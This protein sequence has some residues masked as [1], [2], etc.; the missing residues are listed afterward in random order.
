MFTKVKKIALF[1]LPLVA[2]VSVLSAG[3][4]SDR[5]KRLEDQMKDVRGNNPTGKAGAVT[6]PLSINLEESCGWFFTV[7]ALYWQPDIQNN[8]FAQSD[9]G[10]SAH[11][12]PSVG[13]EYQAKY[14]W[15]WGFRLGAGKLFKHDNW[16]LEAQ[17][18]WFDASAS[19]SVS[20]GSVGTVL[21]TRG[22]AQI[23]GA[24]QIF[25]FCTEANAQGSL[26][27]QSVDLTLSRA[28][29]VSQELSFQPGWGLKASFLNSKESVEYTGGNAVGDTAGLN[30]VV[31]S[32]GYPLG[33]NVKVI[34]KSKFWSIGPKVGVDSTWHVAEG[35][36]LFGNLSA[37]LLYAGQD[38]NYKNTYS[39]DVD[40]NK[41]DVTMKY[42]Q[43]VPT[44]DAFIG[45]RWDGYYSN[46]TQHVGVGLGWEVEYLWNAVQRGA[47][48][49]DDFSVMTTSKDLTMQGLTL[50]LRFDF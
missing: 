50:D 39:V 23:I 17:Y 6:A 12:L 21:P 46:N 16:A 8:S 3:E 25:E 9:A 49:R 13:E 36:S 43:F 42:H 18:T 15:D 24:P 22:T 28:Y 38:F 29:Y 4:M 7:N 47:Y 2:A 31:G 20:A 32:P 27:Y 48:I 34:D 40:N 41:I 14:K 37:S 45:V 10:A 33:A 30:G 19:S 11:A 35:F 1:T 5:T 26:N 44:V